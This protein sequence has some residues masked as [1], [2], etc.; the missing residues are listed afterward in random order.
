MR[1]LLGGMWS[2]WF[3]SCP[4]AEAGTIVPRQAALLLFQ[5]LDR[6]RASYEAGETA[7]VVMR[8]AAA[9]NARLAENHK[10][11]RAA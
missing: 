5:S 11:R 6:M 4:V 2:S 1:R 7:Q 8:E 10:R 9:Q 3:K